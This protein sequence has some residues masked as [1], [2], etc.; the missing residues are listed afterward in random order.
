VSSARCHVG[1][2]TRLAP[3][4]PFPENVKVQRLRIDGFDP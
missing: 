3:A 2:W 4:E 1:L